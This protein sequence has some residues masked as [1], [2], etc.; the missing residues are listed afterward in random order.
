MGRYARSTQIPKNSGGSYTPKDGAK[1]RKYV[2]KEKIG[3]M[4][5]YAMPQITRFPARDRVLADFLKTSILSLYRL[6]IRLDRAEEHEKTPIARELDTEL[7]VLKELIVL[8]SDKDFY[9]RKYAPPLPLRKREV[10]GRYNGDIQKLI[11]G[12]K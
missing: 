10:W 2:L 9:E 12:L 6:A 1:L 3:E 8:A 5:K 7:A 4:M 11:D